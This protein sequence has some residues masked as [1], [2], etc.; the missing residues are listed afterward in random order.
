MSGH[1]GWETFVTWQAGGV[2]LCLEV[3]YIL[4]V[5]KEERYLGET[6]RRS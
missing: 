5:A 4:P 6:V 3:Y 1:R 2:S